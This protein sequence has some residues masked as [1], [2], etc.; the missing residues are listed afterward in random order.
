MKI[1]IFFVIS[2]DN[3]NLYRSI[4]PFYLTMFN[5]LLMIFTNQVNLQANKK[6]MFVYLYIFGSNCIY[7]IFQQLFKYITY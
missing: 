2:N 3:T 1:L 4:Y 6:K 5:Y 7:C